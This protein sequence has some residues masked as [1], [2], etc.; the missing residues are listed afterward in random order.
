MTGSIGRITLLWATSMAMTSPWLAAQAVAQGVKSSTATSQT[1]GG[2][3]DTFGDIVVTANKREQS[4]NKV[5]S[6]I[7]A[8]SGETIKELGIKSVEDV[9]AAVPGLAF[10]HSSTNTPI[11]TLRGVGYNDGSLA[12][13]PAVSVYLDQVPLPFPVLASHSAFD[14]QQIEVLKGPQ[15][16]LFGENSTGGAINYI[17]AKPTNHPEV[18]GDISF[19]RFNDV[20]GDAYI[21]GPLADNLRGRLSVDA[22]N[23]DG[24]QISTTRPYDRNGKTSYVAGRLLLDW[25]TSSAIKFSLNLNAWRDTSQPQA[26]QFIVLFPQSPAQ[27]KPQELTNPFPAADPRAADWSNGVGTPRGDRKFYQAA[28]RTDARLTDTITL[29]ALTSYINFKEAQTI[30]SDGSAL[31]V[32]DIRPN[33]GTI[34]SF[35]QEL[36]LAN[37]DTSSFRWIVGGN[38]ENSKTFEIQDNTYGDDSNSNPGFFNITRGA[39]I[40]TQKIR[41]VAVFGNVEYK[42]TSALSAKGGVRYTDSKNDSSV[43]GFDDGDGRINQLFN[44][45]GSILSGTPNTGLL[46]NAVPYNQRCYALRAPMPGQISYL[47]NLLPTTNTLHEHNLS[48]TAGLNYS[49]DNGALVYVNASRGYKA[50]SFP[51]LAASTTSQYKAA[52][53]ET[54]LAFEGG[55][56]ASFWDRKAH[57][58]AAVFYY[59]YGNKQ[60]LGK[61]QD[62][63]FGT[64]DVLINVPKSRVFGAEAEF[65]VR[66]TPGLSFNAAATYVNSKI[67]DYTGT[68]VL[69]APQNFAGSKLPFAP[70]WNYAFNAEYRFNGD[71]KG[72]P[73]VGVTVAGR[74]QSDTTPR[75]AVTTVPVAAANRVYPGLVH[76]FTTNAYATIDARLGYGPADDSWKVMVWAKNITNK[77]YWNNV[78]TG[79]DF[80]SR[81]AGMPATYGVTASVKIR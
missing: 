18:G 27:V 39:T 30:D 67:T 26:G 22:E 50:G 68:D 81:Y 73:F 57:L 33:N 64:L 76:P 74:S 19:G 3:T 40:E 4:I 52:K 53:Q 36:R 54:V 32:A 78:V 13:Y 6:T 5:G 42:I 58:N 48:W 65:T 37:T 49:F 20:R 75:G 29:T 35:N 51:N 63:V 2:A 25:D 66:P 72:G 77:F 10:S 12:V 79:F 34:K 62:P 55:V 24:W 17:S 16:T 7:V 71:S 60:V 69:G 21:S 61:L 23:S 41:N 45:L 14:L 31:N 1:D 11:L 8:I 56:K 46:N 38:Y 28:L 44:F 43:C 47:P 59:D 70:S 15:G 80:T 9:A